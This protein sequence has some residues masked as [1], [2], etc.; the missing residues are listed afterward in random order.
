MAEKDRIRLAFEDI[1]TKVRRDQV[2]VGPYKE[3]EEK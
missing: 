1:L 3:D 2:W